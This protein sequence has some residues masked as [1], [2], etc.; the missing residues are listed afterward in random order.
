VT[1]DKSHNVMNVVRLLAGLVLALSTSGCGTF[2]A[3]SIARAPNRYPSWLAPHAPVALAF[4]PKLLT[5]FTAQYIEVGP[6]A[7]RLCYRVI[8]P[9]DYHL[10][11]SSSNWWEHDEKQY[12]F[13]FKAS[14]PGQ[15]NQWTAFPRGTVLLLHGYGV[16][17]FSMLPWALRLAQAGWCCVLVDLRGHGK[18]TGRQIYFGVKETE[19]LSQLLNNLGRK[20]ELVEPVDVVGESYGA[21]LA[22]RWKM[23]EPRVQAVVAIAPYA[24]LSNTVM[25]IRQKYADWVPKMMVRAGLK[26]LPAVLQLPASELDTTTVLEHKPVSALFV[27]GGD[28]SVTPVKEVEALR[29]LAL[30][31]SETIVVP[32]AT[33]EALTYYFSELAPGV[34]AWLAGGK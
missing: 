27:A 34:L 25:N 16:A 1:P 18:S 20:K 5:N 30:P 11:I 4:N 26:D 9:G 24:S 21:V 31:G 23:V 19:D 6:P 8:K 13:S 17:Q 22:L 29:S 10:E 12:E 32:D 28:D 33:H 14:V 3:H 2:V 7:A 15:T